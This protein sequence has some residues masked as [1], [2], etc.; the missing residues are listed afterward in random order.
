METGGAGLSGFDKATSKAFR[1][2]APYDGEAPER[3]HTRD[4]AGRL[5]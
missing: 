5:R 2:A 1:E 4:I 3:N